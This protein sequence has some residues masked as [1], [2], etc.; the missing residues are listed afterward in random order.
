[1]IDCNAP[2]NYSKAIPTTR[3]VH[4]YKYDSR[5]IVRRTENNNEFLVLL[6]AAIKIV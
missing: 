3:R 1:M 4:K 5:R 2:H 6:V